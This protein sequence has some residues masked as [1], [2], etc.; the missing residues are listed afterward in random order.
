MK[1]RKVTE[2]YADARAGLIAL[3][4]FEGG[5]HG[6][7]FRTI[8]AALDGALTRIG[9]EEHFTRR[10]GN[11]LLVH[12]HGRI[13]AA[14]VLLVGVSR[15]SDWPE[16]AARLFAHAAVREARR[17]RVGRVALAWPFEGG[18]DDTARD[19]EELLL[20]ARLANYGFERYRTSDTDENP[21]VL[22]EDVTL[23]VPT[24][25]A[26]RLT[27]RV[28]AAAERRSEVRAGA[29][30]RAR[31]LVNTPPNHLSPGLLADQARA[32]AAGKP[33]LTLTLLERA[34]LEERG[35][36]LLLAVGQ[37]AAPPPVLIDL[38]YE[39]PDGAAEG[40]PVVALVGK[41]ITFDS[42][43]L[44]IKTRG[45][46]VDMK[47]D[48]AGAAAVLATMGA[49][50]ELE[51]RVRVHGIVPAAENM[52][53][54]ASYRPGDVLRSLHGKTVEVANTDA[55]GR[56]ALADALT[57]A[58]REGAEELVDLA[59]LTGACAVALGEY[60]AGLFSNRRALA[61]R[62]LKAARDAGESLWE[63]PVDRRLARELKSTVADLKNIGGRYGG[64]IHGAL[65][66][67]EFVEKRTWAHL[68]IAGP[69]FVSRAEQA[70]PKDGTG[71]GVLTLIRWLE[72][73]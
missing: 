64:A 36:G 52:L 59:T 33:S 5:A 23:C 2:S 73:L 3:P 53:G 13:A 1:V 72:D 71:Y 15:A 45:N 47:C 70:V 18:R 30:C 66:L 68:D 55:E 56:L 26:R 39:P 57:Y 16:P 43:G 28:L 32:I 14:R 11:T 48:M 10:D 49:L 7:A 38:R 46:M 12:T 20:G 69:A 58:V 63:L 19:A 40:T 61:D 54:P 62:L 67:E 8:D 34:Q 24:A 41:G 4:V 51:P 42:G 31:D 6:P 27:G 37:G 25:M 21:H 29:V 44:D 9:R 65:F 22:V 50:A 35:F 60:T 17:R